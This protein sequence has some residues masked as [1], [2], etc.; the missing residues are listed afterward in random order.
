MVLLGLCFA[1][2]SAISVPLLRKFCCNL[3]LKVCFFPPSLFRPFCMMQF[4]TWI[5]LYNFGVSNLYTL[6]RILVR[7]GFGF[8]LKLQCSWWLVLC[9]RPWELG[10]LGRSSD[11]A[12]IAY[13][14]NN[15][16]ILR[17]PFSRNSPF[18]HLKCAYLHSPTIFQKPCSC[19]LYYF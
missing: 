4:I 18:G 12:W 8:G 6:S 2:I 7:K 3:L 14:A 5:V 13:Y 19:W 9:P 15:P 1:I 11:K 10:P 17:H 16:A